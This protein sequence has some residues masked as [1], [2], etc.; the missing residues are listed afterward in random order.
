MPSPIGHALAGAAI[1]LA[2]P[3]GHDPK[4]AGKLAVLCAALAAAPDLD[5]LSASHRTVTHSVA[6]VA[7]V[8]IVAAAVTGLV[9]G[10]VQWR[11][12]L[13]CGAAWASHL[14]LD[15]LT[16]DASPPY[17]LQ[18]FWPFTDTWYIS[19]IPVFQGT[20][21]RRIF[22]AASMLQ[23]GL[24]VILELL[25]LGPIAYAAWSVRVKA[26]TRLPPK[27]PGRHHPPK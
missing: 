21:R 16:S 26:A 3:A 2:A 14:V 24:A 11:I 6:A 1:G 9:T 10:R 22:S 18:M 8:I 27:V 23:N 15:W 7:A 19:P 13:V 25:L 5:L 17:G 4:A 12:V 20:E